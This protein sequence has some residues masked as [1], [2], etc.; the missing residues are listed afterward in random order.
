MRQRPAQFVRDER[1]KFR[2]QAVQRLQRLVLL[3]QALVG[4]AQT[5]RLLHDFLLKLQVESLERLPRRR[6]LL[7]GLAQFGLL[8][9]LLCQVVGGARQHRLC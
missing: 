4:L 7:I 1:D 9:L 6:H 2:F 8:A 3:R 5:S